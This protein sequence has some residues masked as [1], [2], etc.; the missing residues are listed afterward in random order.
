MD[1]F[2]KT[3]KARCKEAFG[4]LGFKAFRNNHYRVVN[5]VYQCFR[6]KRSISGFLCDIEW[7]IAPLC[8]GLD[9]KDSVPNFH[10]L[11]RFEDNILFWHYDRKS[12]ESIDLCVNGLI[13]YLKKHLMPFFDQSTNCSNAYKQAMIWEERMRKRYQRNDDSYPLN[14]N[15]YC[16]ALKI[17]DYDEALKYLA[18]YRKN[19]TGDSEGTE[20][21][22]DDP[23]AKEYFEKRLAEWDDKIAHIKARDMDWINNFIQT[24]ER[25]SL[26]NLGLKKDL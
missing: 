6:L 19:I 16:M 21:Y 11:S 2:I 5:D 23:E 4:A 8:V 12:E 17:G 25:K 10:Y 20:S 9:G 13:E 3:Y 26:V 15:Y 7:C 18:Q 24:N 1:Y 22:D 14:T